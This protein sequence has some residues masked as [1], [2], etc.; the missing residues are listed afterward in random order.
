[1]EVAQ[2]DTDAEMEPASVILIVITN[3]AVMMVV[4]EAVELA[5]AE[6]FVKDPAI[7]F[8]N[9]VTSTVPFQFELLNVLLEMQYQQLQ[10]QWADQPSIITMGQPLPQVLVLPHILSPHQPIIMS[11]ILNR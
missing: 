3:T 8:L 10:S 5:K 7:L 2:P 11:P 1:V 4:G 9:N 6:L